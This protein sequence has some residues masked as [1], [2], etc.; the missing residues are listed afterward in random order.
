MSTTECERIGW[1][2]ILGL[3]AVVV[4]VMALSFC[5]TATGTA[6]F[7]TAM[8]YD[9]QVGYGV[10]IILELAKDV[11]PVAVLAL[12]MRRR[13]GLA[14]ALGVG[15]VCAAVFGWL[16]THAT[17]TT[18][19]SSIERNGT[20]KMEIRGNAKAELAKIEQQLAALSRPLPPRPA[21]TVREALTAERVPLSVWQ[22]SQECAKIQESTHFAKACAQVVQLRREL[23]ASE[24]Y[25]RLSTQAAQKHKALA[26]APILATADPLPSA[27]SATLG[28]LV[29]LEGREGVALLLT[30]ALELV[31]SF[32]LAGVAALHRMR[33]RA[34]RTPKG[35]FLASPVLASTGSQGASQVAARLVSRRAQQ[36]ALPE[37]SPKA[38]RSARTSLQ[39]ASCREASNPPSN[40]LPMRPRSPQA[41]PPGNAGGGSA[42]SAY[43][44]H[45]QAFV[46][47]RL[48]QADGES[49]QAKDLRAAYERW[50]TEQQQAPLSMP[51]LATEL[52]AL[53]YD[54]WKSNGLMRYCDLQLVA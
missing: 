41:A 13:L 7:I 15:W 38:V 44:S 32:G 12:W 16:A 14:V 46:R 11:L 5:V 17:I 52:K 50:C 54:K 29:P 23:A 40:V 33:D 2:T 9:T 1:P 31:S 51:K 34:S 42:T 18:A 8:G 28:R 36:V 19:I 48:R 20:W 53:G 39:G 37:P 45:V 24:D 49:L 43:A 4:G 35:G 10:G 22:D 47:E 3:A 30:M 26:E 6:R 21:K 27:F 25:E